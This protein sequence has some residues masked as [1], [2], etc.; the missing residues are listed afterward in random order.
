MSRI[1]LPTGSELFRYRYLLLMAVPAVIWMII[2]NYIPMYGIVIAFKNYSL[3]MPIARAPWIGFAHF[4]EL[5][6]QGGDF[7]RVMRNT[8]G[9]SFLKLFI[10]FP[11][12]I[13]FALMLNEITNMTLKKNIQTITYLPHFLSWIV[14]G[15]I[16]ISWLNADNGLINSLLLKLGLINEA[17]TWLQAPEKFW[18]IVVVSDLWKELGWGAIIYLAAIAGIDPAVYEAATVDGANRFQKM[19]HIT[20]PSIAG[21]ISILLILAISG[22]LNTNFDQILVLQNA[23][24]YATSDVID[25]FVYRFAILEGRADYAQAVALF[26]SVIAFILLWGANG[27]S[28][29]LN[30]HSL[31]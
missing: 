21:T 3:G 18:G 25:V 24:N 9:I 31:F 2:F 14:L 16:M 29:K 20:L 13:V 11:L 27:F 23:K 15:G 12:P 1:K 28:K 5:F 19:M 6:Q 17:Q 10:G 8:L 26:K 7:G 4:Q 22:V 30:G